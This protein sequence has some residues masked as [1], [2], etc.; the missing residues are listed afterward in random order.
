MKA[1]LVVS[2]LTALLASPVF[3]LEGLSDEGLSYAVG[4]AGITFTS[5]PVTL[6]ALNFFYQDSDGAPA[7]GYASAARISLK[8]FVQTVTGLQADFDVGTKSDGTTGLLLRLKFDDLDASATSLGLEDSNGGNRRNFASLSMNNMLLKNAAFLLKA[9]GSASL[10]NS[11]VTLDV[12][13]VEEFGGEVV[14]TDS[15]TGTSLGQ[16]F[17][18]TDVNFS[19]TTFDVVGSGADGA[20]MHVMLSNSTASLN[21]NVTDLKVGGVSAGAINM[22]GFSLAGAEL[23]LRGR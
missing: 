13:V 18:V 10:G 20:G 2:C 9:G 19:G 21:V 11:G 6:G 15:Y 22:T 3:A 12:A 8:D 23:T 1:R 17:K 14:L 5:S 7:G 4:Q 16:T